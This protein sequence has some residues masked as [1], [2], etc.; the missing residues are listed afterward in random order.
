MCYTP[1]RTC[2]AHLILVRQSYILKTVRSAIFTHSSY[3]GQW[4][5]D[6]QM[7]FRHNWR[8]SSIFSYFGIM[9]YRGLNKYKRNKNWPDAIFREYEAE[10][11]SLAWSLFMSYCVY[12][13]QTKISSVLWHLYKCFQTRQ[14]I[15]E[16]KKNCTSSYK[17]SINVMTIFHIVDD[18]EGSRLVVFS[19]SC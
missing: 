14:H 11:L 19:I 16:K 7:Q 3:F 10:N 4:P 8:V 1:L 15:F 18:F 13:I 17:Y 9:N 6:T 2:T 5:V 12:I